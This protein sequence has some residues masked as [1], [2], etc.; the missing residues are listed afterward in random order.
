MFTA[1]P[2]PPMGELS[3]ITFTRFSN[4]P[5]ASEMLPV[6]A[7]AEMSFPLPTTSG[8]MSCLGV[9][10]IDGAVAQALACQASFG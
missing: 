4:E 10:G 8:R 3:L 7:L 1:G 9:I 6:G 5:N 2:V